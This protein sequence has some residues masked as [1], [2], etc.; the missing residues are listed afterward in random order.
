MKVS[1]LW[2]NGIILMFKVLER[3]KCAEGLYLQQSC[4]LEERGQNSHLTDVLMLTAW[5]SLSVWDAVIKSSGKR[6]GS[7][8]ELVSFAAAVDHVTDLHLFTHQTLFFSKQE[9]P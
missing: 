1:K 3:R 8:V 2:Q 7:D 6:D 4:D 5:I 9:V